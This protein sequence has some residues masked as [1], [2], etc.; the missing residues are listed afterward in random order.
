MTETEELKNF[1]VSICLGS[2]QCHLTMSE[3]RNHNAQKHLTVAVLLI[4]MR[5]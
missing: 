3:N 5:L 4:S 2:T 1:V